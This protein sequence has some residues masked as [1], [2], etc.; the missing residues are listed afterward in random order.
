MVDHKNAQERICSWLLTVRS[1]VLRAPL[2]P[3]DPS[4]WSV[5]SKVNRFLGWQMNLVCTNRLDCICGKSVGKTL[6][7]SITKESLKPHCSRDLNHTITW[8]EGCRRS[9]PTGSLQRDFIFILV[10]LF[11][12]CYSS[13]LNQH[14]KRFKFRFLK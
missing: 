8:T 14:L 4:F 5:V 9:L 3:A 1:Q 13:Q 6:K 12:G 2:N 10:A 7:E 11:P